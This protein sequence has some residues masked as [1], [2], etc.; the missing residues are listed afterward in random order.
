M[1]DIIN[2]QILVRD[3]LQRDR[4]GNQCEGDMKCLAFWHSAA[5]AGVAG[6]NT[7][8]TKIIFGHLAAKSGGVECENN[9]HDG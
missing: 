4:H 7:M 2:K 5:T 6:C 9:Q 3:H 1:I 8:M